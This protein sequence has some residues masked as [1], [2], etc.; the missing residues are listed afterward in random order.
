MPVLR[1]LLEALLETLPVPGSGQAALSDGHGNHACLEAGPRAGPLVHPNEAHPR[2]GA[3]HTLHFSTCV[4]Y[5][6]LQRGPDITW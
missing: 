4:L 3:A 5:F 1:A 6:G 2:P